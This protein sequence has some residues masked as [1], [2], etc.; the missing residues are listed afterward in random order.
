MREGVTLITAEKYHRIT[1]KKGFLQSRKNKPVCNI[2]DAVQ[3]LRSKSYS[4]LMV[5]DSKSATEK[6]KK[7]LTII[8]TEVTIVFLE[9]VI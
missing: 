6:E 4:L 5:A 3:S 8:K 2:F 9:I 1:G 7:L